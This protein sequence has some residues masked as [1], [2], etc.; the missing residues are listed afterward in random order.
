VYFLSL[1]AGSE[2]ENMVNKFE[3]RGVF[4]LL[5]GGQLKMY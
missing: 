3:V 5:A 4:K 1:G 2:P